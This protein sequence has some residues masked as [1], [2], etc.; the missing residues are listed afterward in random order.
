[1]YSLLELLGVSSASGSTDQDKVE[2]ENTDIKIL[3]V[4]DNLINRRIASAMLAKAGLSCEVANDGVEALKKYEEHDW[5]IIFMDC[6]MPRMDGFEASREIRRREKG[7]D[8][9]DT[10]IALTANAL[11]GDKERCFEAG[12]D[13]Y[14]SKPLDK[15]K[16]YTMI[17]KYSVEASR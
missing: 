3:L 10:I 1:M 9:H 16:F 7:H 15:A 5:D 12:M 6:Q 11:A 14:L 2:F 13:A 4:E 17:R 8:R